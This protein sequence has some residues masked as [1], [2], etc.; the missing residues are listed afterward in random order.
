MPNYEYDCLACGQRAT[1]LRPIAE[2]DQPY[3]CSKCGGIATRNVVPSSAAALIHS[4]PHSGSRSGETADTNEARPGA[5][6]ARGPGGIIMNNVTLENAGGA[7]IHLENAPHLTLT[8]AKF[9]NNR[10]DI[11]LKNTTATINNIVSER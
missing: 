7:A 8:N 1:A 2:R 11:V 10:Q 6:S 9:K 4:G 5:S 3:T